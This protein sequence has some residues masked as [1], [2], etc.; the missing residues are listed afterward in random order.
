MTGFDASKLFPYR[1]I[2]DHPPVRWPNGARLAVW[3]VPNIEHFHLDLPGPG[4]GRSQL[5]ASRL[6][7]PGRR[8]AFDGDARRNTAMRGSVALNARGRRI[9]TRASCKPA[10]ICDGS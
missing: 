6:R 4:A 2:V 10:P 1:A 8:L 3:V 5:F 9:T 7:Q